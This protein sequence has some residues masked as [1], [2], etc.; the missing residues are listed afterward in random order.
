[1]GLRETALISIKERAYIDLLARRTAE[2]I[3]A[4]MDAREEARTEGVR[5]L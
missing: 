5:K 2:E 4:M 3:G 1:M